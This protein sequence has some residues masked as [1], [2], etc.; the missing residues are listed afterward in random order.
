M[1]AAW[2]Q[3]TAVVEV[4]DMVVAEGLVMAEDAH[5]G[6]NLLSGGSDG[7]NLNKK[8]AQCL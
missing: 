5:G 4:W 8:G 6:N 1:V 3:D 7:E 2:D